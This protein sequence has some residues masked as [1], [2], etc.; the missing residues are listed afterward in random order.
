MSLLHESTINARR[1]YG[2]S[3]T[4]T[5]LQLF[6]K[7][8]SILNMSTPDIGKHKRD[9]TRD[10]VRS[11]DDWKLQFLLDFRDFAIY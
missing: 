6:A 11:A 5:V 2:Y 7:L 8:W 4:A 9:I 1:V 10:P 3:E